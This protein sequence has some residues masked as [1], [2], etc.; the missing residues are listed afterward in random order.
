MDVP[1]SF[2]RAVPVPQPLHKASPP[3]N[4]DARVRTRISGCPRLRPRAYLCKPIAVLRTM[5]S[6]VMALCRPRA[7][8]GK[9]KQ[10]CKA[11]RQTS[12]NS[13]PSCGE[14]T[15]HPEISRLSRKAGDKA[16]K[17]VY[18]AFRS[19]Q[20]LVVSGRPVADNRKAAEFE[21]WSADQL[22]GN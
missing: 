19:P 6:L 14:E 18:L 8:K 9:G 20:P 5:F 3:Y 10:S 7:L 11:K 1:A 12:G 16:F 22:H 13:R 17:Y 21:N 4:V 15:L 2:Y